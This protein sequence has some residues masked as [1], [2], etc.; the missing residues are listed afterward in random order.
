MPTS[1]PLAFIGLGAMGFGMASHLLSQGH[2][3]TG[4]DISPPTLSN[5][6]ALPGG[7]TA[8]TPAAAVRNAQFCICMVATA[9]QAQAVL[10]DGEHP[11]IPALGR[12]AVVLL[13]STVSCAY[14]QSLAQQIK[15]RGRPDILLVDSPVSGG[16]QRAATGTLSIMAAGAASAVTKAHALLLAMSDP[17]KLYIVPGGVGAGSNM[18]MCHQVLAANH[19]LAASEAL[20]FATRLELDPGDAGGKL[21]GSKGW[22]W[23]LENRLPRMLDAEF[24]PVAS[25]VTIILKDTGIVTAEARRR[26][27]GTPMSSVAEQVYLSALGRGFGADDDASMLRMYVEG[28]EKVSHTPATRVRTDEEKLHLVVVLLQ[29]IHMCAAAEALSFAHRVGLD[30]QQVYELCIHAAGG[31]HMLETY[32][33]DVMDVLRGERIVA[34]SIL[35]TIAKQLQEAVDEA[36]RLKMPLFLGSQALHLIRMGLDGEEAGGTEGVASLVKVWGA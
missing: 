7:L 15:H 1:P 11:A 30:L 13:C 27:F 31:S 16:A 35:E 32:G 6:R 9:Q 19:I 2:P 36:Q 18:K 5:F 21:V 3:V 22:S 12:G 23:M 28:R 33:Q 25:A 8:P 26:G 29:G 34:D 17:T 24:R 10:L 4:F 20:G 14:V